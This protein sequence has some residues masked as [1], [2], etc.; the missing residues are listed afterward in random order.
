MEADA[1]GSLRFR[2]FGFPVMLNWSILL[3]G[4]LVAASELPIL[5]IVLF[6][7][8]AII[9]ILIHELGHAFAARSYQARVESIM[10]Y[11]MGGITTWFAGNRLR[12]R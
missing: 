8:A 7:P 10:L 5:A 11:L 1:P 9:S 2:L 6:F 3:L 12:R 4:V